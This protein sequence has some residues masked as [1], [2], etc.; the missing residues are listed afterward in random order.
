MVQLLP[1]RLTLLLVP[2]TSFEHFRASYDCLCRSYF[3]IHGLQRAF[4]VDEACQ[5]SSFSLLG[6]G[7]AV[8]LERAETLVWIGREP[9]D[10]SLFSSPFN[11]ELDQFLRNFSSTV[12]GFSHSGREQGHPSLS[13][14]DPVSTASSQAGFEIVH[15]A[16]DGVYLSVPDSAVRLLEANLPQHWTYSTFPSSPLPLVPVPPQAKDRLRAILKTIRFDHLVASIVNGISVNW[17][18]KDVRYLTGEDPA[19]DILTRHSFS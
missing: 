14:Q 6:L 18:Q 19:S 1:G 16:Q 13:Q 15:R 9:L 10:M 2:L 5:T 12:T 17:L 3:G 11:T 8:G 4:I 7:T